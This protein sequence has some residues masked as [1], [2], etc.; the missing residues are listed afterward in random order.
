MLVGLKSASFFGAL[1]FFLLKRK[2]KRSINRLLG[3][4]IGRKYV[5]I[6]AQYAI[7]FNIYKVAFKLIAL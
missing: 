6:V 1:K 2:R 5:A 7:A 3:K 4:P